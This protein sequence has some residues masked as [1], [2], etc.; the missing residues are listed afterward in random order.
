MKKFVIILFLLAAPLAASADL[1]DAFNVGD[2]SD[3]SNLS[4]MAREAGY[5]TQSSA[6][7]DNI[8]GVV[9]RTALSFVGVIFLVLMVYGGYLWMTARGNDQQIDKARNLIIAAVVGLIIVLSAY[10]LTYFVLSQLSPE[11]LTT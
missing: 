1:S 4:G 10:A 2:D 7:I 8:I 9:I 5:N 6:T 3:G 11:T